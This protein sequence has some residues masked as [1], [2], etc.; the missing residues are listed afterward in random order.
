L[1]EK[2]LLYYKDHPLCEEIF[3]NVFS[4]GIDCVPAVPQH[5]KLV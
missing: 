1:P 5:N 4:S 3:E 2:V